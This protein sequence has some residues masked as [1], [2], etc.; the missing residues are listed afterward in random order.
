MLYL[1][2]YIYRYELQPGS[3]LLLNTLTGAV[4]VVPERMAKVLK[5]HL[6]IETDF[7]APGDLE[8]LILRGYLL[9]EDN[10]NAHVSKWFTDF[11]ERMR[12]LNFTV[13]PTFACNLY[14]PYCFLDPDIRRSKRTLSVEQLN[15]MFSAMDQLIALRSATSVSLELFGGEPFLLANQRLVEAIILHAVGRG[16]PVSA[17]T[18]GTQIN[19][20]F[21]LIERVRGGVRQVQVTVDGPEEIHNKLRVRASGRGSYDEICQNVTRLLQIGIPVVLRV[22]TGS[23]NVPHLPR[24]LS[25]F[26]E[27][28]WT[29]YSNFVC[30][31]AP[32][33]DHADT[34]CIPNY[35]PEFM[36]LRQLHDLFDNWEATRQRYHVA[37]GY[38]L[39]RR[40]RLLRRALFGNDSSPM[41]G[42]DLAGCSA[43]KHHYVVFGADGLLYACPETVGIAEVAIGRYSPDFHID[44]SKWSKWEVDISNT[45]KCA[46][47]SVAPIC[48]GA[49]PWQGFR[50]SSFDAY[51]PHCNYAQQT[52]ETYA[53]LNK[54]RIRELLDLG[55]RSS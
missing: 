9:T 28:G 8:Q 13:C 7:L 19:A 43:S 31:I 22:N 26:E 49:C 51:E 4:D 11:K 36:L 32:I 45:A 20:Y 38:D 14:C 5:P 12:C 15:Q 48:G 41:Q 3:Y 29:S 37:L 25:A 35:L 52:I 53:D 42:F 24:L 54:H 10:E 34:G 1:T 39:E 16:W 44:V 33:N 40:T 21:D 30:Q 2:Q 55:S 50:S 27:M 6:P 46:K 18:N 47:C 17:I 23:N